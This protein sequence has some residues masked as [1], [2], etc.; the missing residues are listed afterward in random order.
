MAGLKIRLT[1]LVVDDL[2]LVYFRHF[3]GVNAGVANITANI[4]EF[5]ALI[6]DRF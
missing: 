3:C 2:A 1:F 5:L 4:C 6:A